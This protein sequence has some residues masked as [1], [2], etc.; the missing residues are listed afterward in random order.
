MVDS[1]TL[2]AAA[3]LGARNRGYRDAW[4][5]RPDNHANEKDEYLRAAY[6]DGYDAAL[7]LR[8]VR[9][10]IIT[11]RGVITEFCT[12]DRAIQLQLDNL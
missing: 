6:A 3:L 7:P 1:F 4:N 11:P 5:H 10:G 2:E 12:L 9:T 8:P